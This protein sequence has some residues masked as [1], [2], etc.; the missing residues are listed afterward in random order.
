M[1]NASSTSL[2]SSEHFRRYRRAGPNTWC[3]VASNPAFEHSK[4]RSCYVMAFS[5][6]YSPYCLQ[7]CAV[8]LDLG[9]IGCLV[10]YRG[11]RESLLILTEPRGT[12][13]GPTALTNAIEG[14]SRKF[15]CTLLHSPGPVPSD[16]GLS[17]RG[18]AELRFYGVLGSSVTLMAVSILRSVLLKHAAHILHQSFELSHPFLT[19]LL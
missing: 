4:G 10:H 19:K 2:A 18:R 13:G 5:R 7:R 15:A 14:R 1:T 9:L 17:D 3:G 12:K 16:P 11:C 6:P 8:V